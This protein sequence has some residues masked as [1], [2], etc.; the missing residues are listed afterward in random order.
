MEKRWLALM[1]G[2]LWLLGS[3]PLLAGD[4]DETGVPLEIRIQGTSAEKALLVDLQERG[5]A[6]LPADAG[7]LLEE[8]GRQAQ[9]GGLGEQQMADLVGYL[10]EE[11]HLASPETPSEPRAWEPLKID[12][13]AQL[14]A[15]AL[16]A[17]VPD[18]VVE[19]ALPQARS[20]VALDR[21]ALFEALTELRDDPAYADI[22]FDSWE[23][24]RASAYLLQR[25]QRQE[26][27]VD[28]DD[29][30]GALGDLDG[31]HRIDPD[32][33][34]ELGLDDIGGENGS[35]AACKKAMRDLDEARR[36]CPIDC[37]DPTVRATE[38]VRAAED[39]V[40][41]SARPYDRACLASL[42][43]RDETTDELPA[44]IAE[45][46]APRAVG[47]LE[48]QGWT[49][50]DP[51][52]TFCGALILG[53]SR[54]ATARHCFFDGRNRLHEWLE[55]R[56]VVLHRSDSPANGWPVRLEPVA[57]ERDEGI[58]PGDFGRH[59]NDYLVLEIDGTLD[60]VRPIRF[61]APLPGEPLWVYGHY[62]L[63]DRTR[64]LREGEM[65]PPWFEGMRW[66]KA[67]Q[68]A[69]LAEERECVIHSCQTDQGYSG[70]PIISRFRSGP[71]GEIVVVGLQLAAPGRGVE[72]CYHL[73]RGGQFNAGLSG[74]F[75]KTE[76]LADLL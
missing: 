22:D 18:A 45:L 36:S 35:A 8:L 29:A 43:V 42:A 23:L 17:A 14:D 58:Q 4:G 50:F 62:R 74:E 73:D 26:R 3:L 19:G 56:E 46:R 32:L 10:Y 20:L 16:A 2:C 15:L 63:F 38:T 49:V 12:Y 6:M 57:I 61:E 55:G 24:E 21:K 30:G 33:R 11:G 71:D 72:D 54:I 31:L 5:V 44:L 67:A 25:Y 34:S 60:D 9:A 75:L 70:T 76:V 69:A 37:F 48:A 40:L 47:V 52:V 66:T 7:A 68:C 1:T 39:E 65:T 13:A 59:E 41:R 51:P 27:P 28:P 64:W 53:E